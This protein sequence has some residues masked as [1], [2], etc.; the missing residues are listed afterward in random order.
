MIDHTGLHFSIQKEAADSMDKALAPLGYELL[1]E[2]PKEMLM[3]QWSLATGFL[4][5]PIFGKRRQ[6][7]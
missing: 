5:A 1:M 7:K 4:L 2:I 6:A 3:V